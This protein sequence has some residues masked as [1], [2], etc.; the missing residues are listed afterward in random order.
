VSAGTGA[1]PSDEVGA[2]TRVLFIGGEG[3]SGS[4]IL[5]RLIAAHPGVCAVGEVKNLFE[6]GIRGDELCGCGVLT[7][8]CELWSPVGERLVGGWSSREGRRVVDFFA[9]LNRPAHL[10]TIVSGQ[11]AMVAEARGI[12]AELYPIVADLSG[13]SVVVDSSKHPGWAYL[14]AG[15][16]TVDMRLVHLVRHPSGVAFSWGRPSIRPQ[17]AGG[18]GDLTIP[19]HSPAEV[20]VRW[21]VFNVLLGRLGE[22]PTPH[23][24]L[25]YEDYVHDPVEAR[26]ACLRLA[27]LEPP[28]GPLTMGGG[29]GIAG[30]PSR[31][32][33]RDA[34]V[35]ADERWLTE[36]S[37]WRH[38][39][40]SAVTWPL[41]TRYGY[42]FARSDPVV[43][44]RP[45]PTH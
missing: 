8:E 35:V 18:P 38:A 22:R 45:A 25:R 26:G 16:D 21:D 14:L 33:D 27:D 30:N 41:R 3:R 19:A 43:P 29:H 5:E 12:L 39:L 7:R 24:L 1:A 4:T 34:P 23:L 9:R 6:R 31:F 32:A 13:A 10:A 15:A 20:A 17:A 40:V 44:L 11:G 2:R 36:M 37:P 28:E 42:R